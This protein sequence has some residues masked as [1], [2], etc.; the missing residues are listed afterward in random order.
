MEETVSVVKIQVCRSVSR[1]VVI[2]F[3]ASLLSL[4]PYK[5]LNKLL[6][7]QNGGTCEHISSV[8]VPLWS[9]GMIITFLLRWSQNANKTLKVS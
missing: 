1:S 8:L 9:T 4:S 7:I 6:I 2:S 5:V 3:P